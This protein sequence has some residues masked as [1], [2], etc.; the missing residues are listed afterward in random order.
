MSR[1]KSGVGVLGNQRPSGAEPP[2]AADEAGSS[3]PAGLA[4]A[5]SA[6]VDQVALLIDGDDGIR[7]LARFDGH[8]RLMPVRIEFL[9][10][11]I[12]LGDLRSTEGGLQSLQ[13][14]LGAGFERLRR[15][16]FGGERLLESVLHRQQI[17]GEFFDRVLVGLRDIGLRLFA[18][19]VGVGAR[20]KPR[21][22][23]VGH[24]G[25]GLFQELGQIGRRIE[26]RAVGDFF[27]GLGRDHI[28]RFLQ[29]RIVG[30]HGQ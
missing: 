30:F 23:E 27:T 26:W 7:R 18:R 6:V 10:G 21:V 11:W 14:Q 29:A 24:F 22:A 12:D 2:C 25:L 16:F 13:R 17:L 1:A 8:H 3:L 20:A 28:G 19:V 9:A 5:T 15:H 4:T